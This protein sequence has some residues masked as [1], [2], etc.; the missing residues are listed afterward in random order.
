MMFLFQENVTV[1]PWWSVIVVA[2]ISAIPGTVAALTSRKAKGAARAAVEQSKANHNAIHDVHVSVDGRMARLLEVTEAMARLQ[3]AAEQRA[4]E[5]RR[6]LIEAAAAAP[7]KPGPE[8][9]GLT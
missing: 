2:I 7:V 8:G 4:E 9:G 1:A 6:R 3:G 5:D